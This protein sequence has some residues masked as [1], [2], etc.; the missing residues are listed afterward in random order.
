MIP[1]QLPT[2]TTFPPLLQTLSMIPGNTT[3]SIE[4]NTIWT[5]TTTTAARMVAHTRTGIATFPPP[6]AQFAEPI[7]TDV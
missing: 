5:V 4:S 7:A 2:M 6:D 3:S 1:P